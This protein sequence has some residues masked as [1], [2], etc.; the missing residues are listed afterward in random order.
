MTDLLQRYQP[1]LQQLAATD[2]QEWSTELPQQIAQ[3]LDPKRYGDLPRWQK[4]LAQLPGWQEDPVSDA[5]P[6]L[7]RSCARI[8]G[9][10]DDQAQ[11]KE[12]QSP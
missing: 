7:N 9:Q 1:F 10:P 12:C 3:G 4:V 8:L 2:L 6:A 5:L 11:E